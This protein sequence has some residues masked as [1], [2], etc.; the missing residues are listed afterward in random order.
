[1]QSY[2]GRCNRSVYNCCTDDC[3]STILKE[4]DVDIVKN[5]DA[6]SIVKENDLNPNDSVRL[7]DDG[8]KAVKALKDYILKELGNI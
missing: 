5:I 3:V 8:E 6:E 4:K 2:F 7:D 1:M